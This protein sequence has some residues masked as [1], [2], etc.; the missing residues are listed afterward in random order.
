MEDILNFCQ[1]TE[2][3][4][5]AGQPTVGQFQTIKNAG[6][7]TVVNLAMSDASNAVPEEEKTV[8]EL[9][10]NYVH[11]PVPFDQPEI[12]HLKTF[13][14]VMDALSNEKIFVHCALNLRVSVFVYQYL[15]IRKKFT[16]QLATTPMLEKWLPQM[17]AEWQRIL[18]LTPGELGF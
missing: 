3:I 1:I 15:T 14:G 2:S 12:R 17:D 5:T 18:K 4:A 9:G 10:M 7:S 11:L 6:Y 13:F 16:P 8:T